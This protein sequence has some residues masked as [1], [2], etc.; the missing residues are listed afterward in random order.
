MKFNLKKS[1]VI[2]I[3]RKIFKNIKLTV[4]D[5]NI[6]HVKELKILGYWFNESMNN[7]KYLVNN[8]AKVRLNMFGMKPNGLKAFLYNTFCLSK[9]TYSIE[10]MNINEKTINIL[11][12]MQNSL[13]RYML[14]FNKSSH[15]SNILKALKILKIKHLIC[16]YKINFIKQLVNHS[17]CKQILNKIIDNRNWVL[18]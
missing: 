9:T 4:N 2:N 15:M 11:N 18:I 10:L 5:I 17:L 16:K 8:F 6:D 1:K 3:G 7:N 14:R 13:I 12:V